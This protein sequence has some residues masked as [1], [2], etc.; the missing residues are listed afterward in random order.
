MVWVWCWL[1]LSQVTKRKDKLY[2]KTRYWIWHW[3]PPL[4]T[5]IDLGYR[6]G[7]YFVFSGGCLVIPNTSVVN[8]DI[9]L[10]KNIYQGMLFTD[11]MYLI[12]L[13]SLGSPW[14]QFYFLPLSKLDLL[15][16]SLLH[17]FFLFHTLYFFT[18]SY[19]KWSILHGIENAY[20]TCAFWSSVIMIWWE[21]NS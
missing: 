3:Y 5:N 20:S 4:N 7:Q 19:S 15:N 6:L 14:N 11:P 17:I 10:L 8:N 21:T 13:Y 16:L 2:N 1:L 9:V 12:F 18:F